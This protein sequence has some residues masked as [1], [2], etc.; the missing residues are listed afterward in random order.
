ML[1]IATD[2]AAKFGQVLQIAAGS[3]P[4]AG[5]ML[6]IAADSAPKAQQDWIAVP[7]GAMLD[8]PRARCARTKVRYSCKRCVSHWLRTQWPRS[9]VRVLMLY[10]LAPLDAYLD[11]TDFQPGARS[12]E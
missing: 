2:S 8:P 12:A 3:A 5:Q 7:F 4:K 11:A 10:P 9:S 6:Q 1:Q